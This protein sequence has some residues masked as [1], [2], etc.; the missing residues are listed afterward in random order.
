M[1]ADSDS[2][3]ILKT[4]NPNV[5]EE[6]NFENPHDIIVSP[7]GTSIFVTELQPFRVWKF[8]IGENIYYF[9]MLA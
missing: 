9:L 2:G 5:Q 8:R 7:N 3:R 4:F 1:N 6:L